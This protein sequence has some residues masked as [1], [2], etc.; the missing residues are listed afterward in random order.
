[1]RSLF[2]SLSVAT[3]LLFAALLGL[4]AN[5]S[6]AGIGGGGGSSNAG[7]PI[8]GSGGGGPVEYAELINTDNGLPYNAEIASKLDK[9][10]RSE[11]REGETATAASNLLTQPC[12]GSHNANDCVLWYDQS[13]TSPSTSSDTWYEIHTAYPNSAQPLVSPEIAVGYNMKVWR[14]NPAANNFE[15]IFERRVGLGSSET[16]SKPSQIPSSERAGFWGQALQQRWWYGGQTQDRGQ[17]SFSIAGR[18]AGMIGNT[19]DYERSNCRSRYEGGGNGN[20]TFKG[21]RVGSFARPDNSAPNIGGYCYW[22]GADIGP[23][24]FRW[25]NAGVNDLAKKYGRPGFGNNPGNKPP[26]DEFG[27]SGGTGRG[28]KQAGLK[29][30]IYV[31]WR[32]PLSA[33]GSNGF[34]YR[35]DGAP[36]LFYV[37]QFVAIDHR[38]NIINEAGSGF[39]YAGQFLKAFVPNPI[40]PPPDK[41]GG[42]GG[43]DPDVENCGDIPPPNMPYQGSEPM[44]GASLDAEQTLQTRE[45]SHQQILAEPTAGLEPFQAIF[46]TRA[47]ITHFTPQ[48]PFSSS[49]I[50]R[51]GTTY[52]GKYI[53]YGAER[54]GYLVERRPSPL[55]PAPGDRALTNGIDPSLQEARIGSAAWVDPVSGDT[56]FNEVSRPS[57]GVDFPMTWLRPTLNSPCVADPPTPAA[58]GS[59]GWPS[60]LTSCP[61]GGDGGPPVVFNAWDDLITGGLDWESRWVSAT[62]PGANP[63]DFG[64][65]RQQ[66]LRCSSPGYGMQPSQN[67]PVA[68]QCGNDYVRL[69]GDVVNR[70]DQ[71][72]QGYF[73]TADDDGNAAETARA[74]IILDLAGSPANVLEDN[75]TQIAL[76]ERNAGPYG[77]YPPIRNTLSGNIEVNACRQGLQPSM[78]GHGSVRL[79]TGNGNKIS[80]RP[81]DNAGAGNETG[82][83]ECRGWVVDWKWKKADE[84]E[85]ACANTKPKPDDFVSTL[86]RS[87]TNNRLERSGTGMYGFNDPGVGRDSRRAYDP[88]D[89]KGAPFIGKFPATEGN[90][91]KCDGADKGNAKDDYRQGGH[92]HLVRESDIGWGR[93]N[94]TS[95]LPTGDSEGVGYN[96]VAHFA[97]LTQAD[98]DAGASWRLR[99]SYEG[100]PNLIWSYHANSTSAADPDLSAFIKVYGPRADR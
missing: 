73:L 42:G 10:R 35:I 98:F 80:T 46:P 41:P 17:G 28:I 66:S 7:Y 40:G 67:Q 85:S 74:R 95:P 72:A 18:S 91:A 68:Q 36:G 82:S 37:V 99:A 57:S 44:L 94:S 23:R 78:A 19:G 11:G 93:N 43:C 15:L 34:S 84:T 87:L 30:A 6:A 25:S 89:F 52:D 26:D 4:P 64:R 88:A 65:V 100:F 50:N 21:K 55:S 79:F 31:Q 77:A 60:S 16:D 49:V 92:W 47:T 86:S 12:A 56:V 9:W 1:M 38:E 59:T 54:R 83:D 8:G 5:A 70:S 76:Y 20:R 22:E 29:E 61:M 2:V 96:V 97:G 27:A 48:M 14:E 32:L 75:L 62:V 39:T 71:L 3:A 53:S 90:F 81:V 33:G 51:A 63:F 69:P 24:H 45:Y 58:G 13:Q